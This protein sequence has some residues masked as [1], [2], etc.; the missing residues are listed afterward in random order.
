VNVSRFLP[1]DPQ[2][3]EQPL[4]A[5]IGELNAARGRLGAW[6]IEALLALVDDFGRR[7]LRDQR[8]RS[9]EG[10]AFLSAWLGRTNLQKILDLNMQGNAKLLDGFQPWGRDFLAAKP[11]G[12]VAMWMAGNVPTLPLFSLVPA[13]LAKNV[14]LVKLAYADPQG[15]DRL[16]AV[17][18]EAEAG[19]LRG[20]DLLAA[21]AVVW[22]DYRRAELNDAMSLAADARVIWGGQA[23]VKAVS[24]LPRR[25]H[26]VD[27]VFG[28]KYSIALIDR[29]RLESGGKPLEDA[30]AG[31]VRDVAA[32]DQRGC[33]APQTIFI[34]RNARLS[35]A[36]VGALFAR[37]LERLPPKPGLDAYTTV[38]IMEIRARW[39]LDESRDCLASADGA[40]WTVCMDRE[41]SLKEA[42]QSRTVFLTEV[43]S[44][45]DIIPLLSPKVQTVGIAFAEPHTATAF[46][47]AATA[48]GVARC[49]RPGLMNAF[50]SPWD[51]KLLVSQLV[52][53][54]TLKP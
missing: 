37:Q 49:V 45:R 11:Q 10:A 38:R 8:T 22:F 5:I 40:N 30:V 24:A 26:C 31:L 48:A 12:L 2:P 3:I 6:P 42:V 14:C 32:F 51:G 25:E 36:D 52:R 44:W 13:L 21:A 35:L 29:Q 47:E 1:T 9:L 39:A 54:V 18:G 23:A 7:L 50:E 53:W 33:S 27:I 4:P 19:G 15:M 16:L 17:L 41:P 28:P 43:E 34:E 46:A 20:S